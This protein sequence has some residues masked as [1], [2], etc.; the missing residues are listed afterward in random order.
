MSLRLLTICAVAMLAACGSNRHCIGEFPYQRAAT[1][2]PPAEVE[3]LSTPESVAALRIP[4]AP[5]ESVPYARN[6]PDPENPGS[7]RVQCLDVPPPMTVVPET[8]PA[9][10]AAES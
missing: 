10:A 3:G 5:A 4:P 7:T 1:L 2:A 9:P 8:D 6:V